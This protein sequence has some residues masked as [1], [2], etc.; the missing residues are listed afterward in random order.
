MLRGSSKHQ[1]R[2]ILVVEDDA[3]TRTGIEKLL[4]I[5]GYA[6]NSACNEEDAVAKATCKH[7]DLMLVSPGSKPLQVTDMARR[8]RTRAALNDSVPI[9]I[10]CVESIVEGGE[11]NIGDN[12]YLIRPDNFNQVRALVRRLLTNVPDGFQGGSAALSRRS[13][14]VLTT[15]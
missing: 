2:L 8:I 11:V 9:V 4:E 5:D 12:V 7:P 3:E 10:F 14:S 6:V 13:D 15:R 1:G